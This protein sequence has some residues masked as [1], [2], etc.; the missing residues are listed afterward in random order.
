MTSP[1]LLLVN[2]SK[3]GS[4]RDHSTSTVDENVMVETMF[5]AIAGVHGLGR[6]LVGIYI[7]PGA[8]QKVVNAHK[9]LCETC[10]VKVQLPSSPMGFYSVYDGGDHP[11]LCTIHVGPDKRETPAV[12]VFDAHE[13][14]NEDGELASLHHRVASQEVAVLGVIFFGDLCLHDNYKKRANAGHTPQLSKEL[15]KLARTRGRAIMD[16]IKS[17]DIEFRYLKHSQQAL[18][19]RAAPAHPLPTRHR[20]NPA[21]LLPSASASAGL[22]GVTARIANLRLSAGA[23][24][25]AQAPRGNKIPTR[26]AYKKAGQGNDTSGRRCAVRMDDP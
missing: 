16:L 9:A 5:K 22:G 23:R 25:P 1:G 13:P 14:H 15:R 21:P 24:T 20:S 4:V 26:S 12:L 2:P 17:G 8:Y 10:E 6:D 18:A 3:G 7:S 11:L 19:R